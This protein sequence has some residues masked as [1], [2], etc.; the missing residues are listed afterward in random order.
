MLQDETCLVS[1]LVSK[2]SQDLRRDTLS[3]IRDETR[4]TTCLVLFSRQD[5]MRQLMKSLVS[6]RMCRK[7]QTELLNL[8]QELLN[9]YEIFP[10]KSVPS[11]ITSKGVYPTKQKEYVNIF[12]DPSNQL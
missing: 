11:F 6:F 1:R 5:K 2:T 4:L 10:L 8:C 7:I 3:E 9:E 12:N